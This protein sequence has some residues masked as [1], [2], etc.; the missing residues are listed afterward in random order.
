MNVKNV[1]NSMIRRGFP[2]ALLVQTAHARKSNAG[3]AGIGLQLPQDRRDAALIDST[4]QVLV[5]LIEEL[6]VACPDYRFGQ[7]VLNLAFLARD[8]GDRLAW[9]LED[10]EFVEAARKHLADW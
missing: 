7:L 8:D 5:K 4:R 3:I 10:I 6:S 1:L 2:V 9:Y